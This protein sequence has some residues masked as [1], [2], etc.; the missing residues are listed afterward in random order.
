MQKNPVKPYDIIGQLGRLPPPLTTGR[1]IAV[2]FGKNASKRYIAPLKTPYLSMVEGR[3]W[4]LY[5]N[6]DNNKLTAFLWAR[7][8]CY[9]KHSSTIQ[10]NR[11]NTSQHTP[12]KCRRD[13]L[14]G[15]LRVRIAYYTKTMH[16]TVNSSEYSAKKTHLAFVTIPL[17]QWLPLS[18]SPKLLILR[19]LLM[20]T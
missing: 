16:A 17:L 1:E 3:S 7:F 10:C 18:R 11:L 13:W 4:T 6:L 9:N 19:L 15:S 5:K 2:T 14:T 8:R 12:S 20:L